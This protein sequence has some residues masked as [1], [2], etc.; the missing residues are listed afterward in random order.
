MQLSEIVRIEL[1]Q[2]IHPRRELKKIIKDAQKNLGHFS[3]T[4]KNIEKT[5]ISLTSAGALKHS[6]IAISEKSHSTHA[7]RAYHCYLYDPWG[8]TIHLAEDLK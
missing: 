2:Q 3:L 7:V 8:N 6:Q 4:V 1:S 5:V